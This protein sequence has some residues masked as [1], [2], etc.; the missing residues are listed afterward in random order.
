MAALL[1]DMTSKS[2]GFGLQPQP[3]SLRA[4]L[5][6]QLGLQVHPAGANRALL[7]LR[8]KGFTLVTRSESFQ[9]LVLGDKNP[10]TSQLPPRETD[11]RRD[12]AKR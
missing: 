3:F 5:A 1:F 4:L 11:R 12:C 7:G 8:H 10:E 6:R 9:F 2:D